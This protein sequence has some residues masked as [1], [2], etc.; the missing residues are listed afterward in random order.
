[1]TI[2]NQYKPSDAKSPRRLNWGCVLAFFLVPVGLILLAGLSA[3]LVWTIREYSGRTAFQQRLRQMAAEGIPVDSASTDAKYLSE[4]S[5][6]HSDRWVALLDSLESP[7]FRQKS[8]GVFDFDPALDEAVFSPDGE[9]QFD[10]TA[11]QF[12]AEHAQEI[13]QIVELAR[14]RE[15]VTFPIF[16]DSWNTLLPHSQAMRVASR[17]MW[18][19]GLIAIRDQDSPRIRRAIETILG[20]SKVCSAEPFVISRLVCLSQVY[21]AVDL[22][23]LAIENQRLDSADL[24]ALL[25]LLLEESKLDDTWQTAMRGERAISIP[26]FIDP[27]LTSTGASKTTIPPRGRDGI[28]YLDLMAKAEQLE[29]PDIDAL[30]DAGKTMKRE[31][32]RLLRHGSW[33]T[34]IDG[35]MTG[36]MAPAFEPFAEALVRKLILC[37]LGAVAIKLE[38]FRLATGELPQNLDELEL[39]RSDLMPPGHKPF[40]YQ[41]ASDGK[42]TLW[43][44]SLMAGMPGEPVVTSTPDQPP[45]S[46]GLPH[47]VEDNARVTWRFGQ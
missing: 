44:F 32:D 21:V 28:L 35:I 7:E 25:P 26:N 31:L 39:P 41:R 36:V 13:E 24:E 4:T 3:R 15:P 16:F 10:Q 47:I 46:D 29:T 33:L 1:M 20:N 40:G 9:W 34:T 43:G 14:H 2:G 17:L 37:R 30:R 6:E 27:N 5:S 19:D 8:T 22:L 42:A 45:P 38:L 12:L 11:R 23:K 18:L